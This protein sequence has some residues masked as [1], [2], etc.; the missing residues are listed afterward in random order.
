FPRRRSRRII[1]RTAVYGPVRT[2]AW[3]G[4]SREAPPYPD[5]SPCPFQSHD[6]WFFGRR[7]LGSKTETLCGGRLLQ[8]HRTRLMSSGLAPVTK[9][10]TSSPAAPRSI[11]LRARRH[12]R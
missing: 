12:E 4:R 6:N 2:V 5:F 1:D 9:L 7:P 8:R 11:S 10:G 3:E